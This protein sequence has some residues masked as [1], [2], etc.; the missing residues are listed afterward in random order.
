MLS[1][2]MAASLSPMVGKKSFTDAA[3]ASDVTV[4]W[5]LRSAMFPVVQL[6]IQRVTIVSAI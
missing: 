2:I 1:G 6:Y 5:L 4:Q 3:M